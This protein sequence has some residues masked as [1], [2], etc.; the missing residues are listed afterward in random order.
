MGSL[1]A[2]HHQPEGERFQPLALRSSLDLLVHDIDMVTLVVHHAQQMI[3]TTATAATIADEK[4]G[5]S[6]TDVD[7]FCDH[8][9]A[10]GSSHNTVRA[11]RTDLQMLLA[12]EPDITLA[13]FSDTAA[14]WLT[15]NRE[16][17]AASTINRR[18]AAYNKF[19]D[20]KGVPG[21]QDYRR[22]RSA[23]RR[24][25]NIDF[26]AITGVL[27]QLRDPTNPLGL[28]TSEIQNAYAMVSLCGLSGLRIHEAVGTRWEDFMDSDGTTVE[29]LVRGKGGKERVVPLPYK[30]MMHQELLG[31]RELHTLREV[32]PARHLITKVFAAAGYPKVE[33]HQ[34]RHAF[35][36]AAYNASHDIVTVQKL[37]GH[38]DVT[39][40]QRYI[41]TPY[42][43]GA[44]IV[45]GLE[46]DT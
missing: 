39:T 26:K 29:V 8:L 28:T 5:I 41:D 30:H 16:R 12:D 21:L 2:R 7:E 24:K 20:Y 40:T 38:S 9:T 37:M 11:Y 3:H 19:A 32:R 15:A 44:T 1:G 45:A 35:G 33:S 27:E 14:A 43:T 13:S 46:T 23:P 17:W 10:W 25:R 34:L 4:D 42:K 22:P 31:T 18:L 6:T 36:T